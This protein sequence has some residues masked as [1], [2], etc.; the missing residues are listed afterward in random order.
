MF[1]EDR[2]VYYWGLFIL[3]LYIFRYSWRTDTCSYIPGD[4]SFYF[5]IFLGILRGQMGIFLGI[6]HS[7][8][9]Y[10]LG[11]LGGQMDI[12]LWIFHYIFIYF[13]YSGRTDGYIPGNFSFYFIYFRYSRRTDRYMYIP[14]DFSFYFYI[15]LGI[16]GGQMGIFLG[17][18]LL[19]L[20]ELL[21]FVILS[22]VL[23]VKRCRCFMSTK[24]EED[25]KQELSQYS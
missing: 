15:F 5:Y 11:I 7:I 16:L 19:T 12:F 6:S 14:W 22:V 2:W 1:S 21:E 18:S 4:F 9:I 20:S 24:K 17:A 13:R 10:F 23:V 8:F 3:F 25:C